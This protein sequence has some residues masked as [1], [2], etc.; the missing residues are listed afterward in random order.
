LDE[1]GGLIAS[2]VRMLDKDEIYVQTLTPDRV[3]TKNTASKDVYK[4]LGATVCNEAR[5]SPRYTWTAFVNG[6]RVDTGAVLPD[7]NDGTKYVYTNKGTQTEIYIDDADQTVRVVEINY[8]LG[9]VSKVRSDDKGEYITVRTLSDGAAQLNDKTFYAEGWS[10]DDYVIFTIDYVEADDDFII[11][12]VMA[13]TEVTGIV[14]RVENDT[15]NLSGN[16]VTGATY[17]TMDGTKYT[18][19]AG[20]DATPAQQEHMVYDLDD[21]TNVPKHPTLNEE[22]VIYCDPLGYIVAYDKVEAE[23]NQYLYVEDSDEELRD[24]VA[25]IILTDATNPKVD[26]NRSLTGTTGKVLQRFNR[27]TNDFVTYNDDDGNNDVTSAIRW[28]INK[29]TAGTNRTNIDGLIWKYSV[30]SSGVYK[31][32]YIDPA[33]ADALPKAERQSAWENA[34]IHNGKAYIEVGEDNLIVD[35]KTVFVDTINDKV[36][37]GYDEVPN[38]DDADI[39]FVVKNY[40]AKVVFIL[41][42]N[43]YDSASTYFVLNGNTRVSLKYDGDEYWEYD[44]AY[45]NGEKT[46]L[47]VKYGAD[48]DNPNTFLKAVNN[49]G[50]AFP[51][52]YQ[53][54][55]TTGDGS[56]ITEVEEIVPATADRLT[57]YAVADG[58]FWAAIAANGPSTGAMRDEDKYNFDDE[59]IFVVIERT[60]K[61]DGSGYDWS[62][63]PGDVNDMDDDDTGFDVEYVQV[64]K[65][66]GAD[67]DHAELVYIYRTSTANPGGASAGKG[68]YFDYES[69]IFSN[70]MGRVTL[71]VERPEWLDH[72]GNGNPLLFTCDI[73][74][75]G[76][77]YVNDWTGDPVVGTQTN[78]LDPAQDKGSFTWTE[79]GFDP[80]DVITVEDFKWTNLGSQTYKIKYK[81]YDGVDLTVGTGRNADLVKGTDT[82][83]TI[84]INGT[85]TLKFKLNDKKYA[86]ATVD[87]KTEGL[88]TG[89]TAMT[90]TTNASLTETG[91]AVDVGSLNAA[92]TAVVHDREDYVYVYIDVAKLTAA[93]SKYD[94]LRGADVT[95]KQ[96][97][98][99][100]DNNDG[101]AQAVSVFGATGY[102]DTLKIEMKPDTTADIVGLDNNE[103]ITVTPTITSSGTSH[104]QA[105]NVVIETSAGTLTFKNVKAGTPADPQYLRIDGDDITV[106]KITVSV[107]LDRVKVKS[108]S[109]NGYDMTI[110]FNQGVVKSGSAKLTTTEFSD[111]TNATPHNEAAHHAASKIEAVEHTA[112]S[113]TVVIHFDHTLADGDAIALAGSTVLC[114]SDTA[115]N[116]ALDA[117]VFYVVSMA[118]GKAN[119]V[120]DVA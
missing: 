34:E 96:F 79:D 93:V 2:N 83:E 19:S 30:N 57:P 116:Y 61:K 84:N 108:V 80:S 41:D 52:I 111:A 118:E 90:G 120:A 32:T 15:A 51:V 59:T 4:D 70:G 107:A 105:Y 63:F 3:Y 54:R 86:D 12:E 102:T 46:T 7:S 99:I 25:R 10:E 95:T 27:T 48:K 26:V 6:E 55:K 92:K 40:V 5:N 74:V 100:G 109:L 22:Y 29:D 21:P 94:I 35:K 38:V 76:R 98:T 43:I 33:D 50:S 103:L 89:T 20:V 24:W 81:S 101:T 1:D 8:Y 53:I 65:K 119:F 69:V 17:L 82:A 85:P 56:Y 13:P 78:R 117:T 37:T 16:K 64:L 110:V 91:E 71:D 31:L 23:S 9:Q 72:D 75:N 73:V 77:V 67:D 28:V 106:T 44:K 114:K 68:K 18:Y 88:Y 58:A 45:V 87:Y 104:A 49:P 47:T 115:T 42:G 113:D 36:Y 66:S 11:R 97:G 112:G 14:E 62:V 39:A 60:L